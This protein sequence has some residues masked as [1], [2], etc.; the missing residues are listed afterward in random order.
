MHLCLCIKKCGYFC[1]ILTTELHR[2]IDRLTQRNLHAQILKHMKKLFLFCL[3]LFYSFP[4]F[5]QVTISS[6]D[7]PVSGDTVVF[8]SALISIPGQGFPT[9]ESHTWDYSWFPF[10]E[11]EVTTYLDVSSLNM[12]Y[13]AAFNNPLFPDYIAS[14]AIE[15]AF[16]DL[17]GMPVSDPLT[18][19]RNTP[20]GF[21]IVG[22]AGEYMGFPVP[23]QNDTMD[24]F[25]G[26]PL[27]YGDTSFSHSRVNQDIP[28]LGHV[29]RQVIR[30]TIADGWGSLSTPY[31]T[32]DVLRVRSDATYR[33]SVRVDTL[34]AFPPLVTQRT[35]YLFLA[36]DYGHPLLSIE[37]L[38]GQ[39]A[40]V[41]YI[42]SLRSTHQ[43]YSQHL[44]VSPSLY[45]N[46]FSTS[47]TICWGDYPFHTLDVYN[48]YGQLVFSVD[49]KGSGVYT[50]D[51]H[52]FPSPGIYL[53]ELRCSSGLVSRLR[54]VKVK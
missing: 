44:D 35:E 49:V 28:A 31:G 25:Y 50:L 20:S 4:C 29:E 5:S 42:D 40:R 11:Q 41:T 27:N 38:D 48:H 18:F 14:Y 2:V 46:P 12:I 21:G 43:S 34:P 53:F 54:G 6:G 47:A 10:H 3:I 39:N 1:M 52:R 37:V 45:P 17:P 30:Q 36:K 23:G 51:G 33:D 32:F 26:F 16:M 13:Q 15:G 24:V 7:M 22:Y 8:S 19:F 9:G